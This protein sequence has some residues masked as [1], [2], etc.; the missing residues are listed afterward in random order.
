MRKTI[1]LPKFQGL[2]PLQLKSRYLHLSN[3]VMWALTLI[4]STSIIVSPTALGQ[5]WSSLKRLH[6]SNAWAD[7]ILHKVVGGGARGRRG[8]AWDGCSE[9]SVQSVSQ[10][11]SATNLYTLHLQ[12][13]NNH[14]RQKLITVK[15]KWK[16]REKIRCCS[17]RGFVQLLE[18]WA[19]V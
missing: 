2:R 15:K 7:Q 8:E 11:S 10:Q 3:R 19:L 14:N 13:L 4:F 5:F 18:L 12:Y 6:A 1:I 16:K 9:F 17:G